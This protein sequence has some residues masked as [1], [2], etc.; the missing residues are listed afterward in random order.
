MKQYTEQPFPDLVESVAQHRGPV[1]SLR[2]GD[3]QGPTEVLTGPLKERLQEV[4][5][6][7]GLDEREK[8]VKKIAKGTD[9][10]QGERKQDTII[11]T[12]RS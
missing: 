2:C 4:M 1:I 5:P 3:K 7:A 8:S 9:N 10:I 12:A 11:P 6:K